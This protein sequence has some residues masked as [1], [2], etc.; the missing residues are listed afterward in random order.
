MI[1]RKF[2]GEVVRVSGER[3]AELVGRRGG[4][5]GD[6]RRGQ[7]DGAARARVARPGPAVLGARG[8][9]GV[10]GGGGSCR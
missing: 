2:V 7:R 1:G 9:D 4:V 10:L 8:R 6:R 5:A 3:G